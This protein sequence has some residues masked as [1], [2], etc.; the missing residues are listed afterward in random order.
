M[1]NFLNNFHAVITHESVDVYM[2]L[3]LLLGLALFL[4][5]MSIRMWR[6]RSV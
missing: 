2:V 5:G 6:L 3:N 1:Q 4:F